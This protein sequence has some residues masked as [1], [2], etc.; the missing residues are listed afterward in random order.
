MR[1]D[2]RQALLLPLHPTRRVGPASVQVTGAS[3][4]LPRWKPSNGDHRERVSFS[5]SCRL[6]PPTQI[7]AAASLPWAVISLHIH[8]ARAS[9]VFFVFPRMCVYCGRP[10]WAWTTSW[11]FTM[12]IRPGGTFPDNWHHHFLQGDLKKKSFL[13]GSGISKKKVRLKDQSNTPMSF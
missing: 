3:S 5:C 4:L 8:T 2:R 12:H 7:A 13:Q 9:A 10:F 6:Q 1:P 11:A